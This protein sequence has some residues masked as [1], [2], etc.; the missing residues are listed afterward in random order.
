MASALKT[1]SKHADEEWLIRDA[2]R[3][4]G[5]RMSLRDLRSALEGM[6]HFKG[7]SRESSNKRIQRA[8]D[9]LEGFVITREFSEQSG[10]ERATHVS[11]IGDGRSF[12]SFVEGLKAKG[13]NRAALALALS[14]AEKALRNQLPRPYFEQLEELFNIASLEVDSISSQAAYAADPAWD[15]KAL[16]DSV[17]VTQKGVQERPRAAFDSAVLD[18]AYEAIARHKAVSFVYEGKR[19]KGR[20][21]VVCGLTGIVFRG[22]KVYLVGCDLSRKSSE[23]RA[24]SGNRVHHIQVEDEMTF[25]KPA[26]FSLRKYVEVDNEL[27]TVVEAG[28]KD[29]VRIV[30]RVLPNPMAGYDG[31]LATDELLDSEVQGLESLERLDDGS[32]R[33]AFFRRD[34]YEF[35][36][37][38]LKFGPSLA[39]EL[40]KT[41][42]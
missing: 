32:Y 6:A 3:R 21:K 4:V 18:V 34:T 15:I 42:F 37:W 9:R 20:N 7:M 30:V 26:G 31:Y 39:V 29:K 38:L 14:L 5:G 36:Q 24:W 41:F 11:L 28:V 17:M 19:R 10:G 35:R 27:E 25:R 16:A 8:L 33:A 2:L 22:A 12:E 23:M 13:Q 40:P 1:A